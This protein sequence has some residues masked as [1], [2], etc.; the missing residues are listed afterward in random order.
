MD[1][2]GLLCHMTLTSWQGADA[3]RYR[4]PGDL[5]DEMQNDEMRILVG[6]AE[7]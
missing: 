7:P 4:V 3:E 2:L 6:R 5:D 1:F